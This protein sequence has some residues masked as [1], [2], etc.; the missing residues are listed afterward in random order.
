[1]P[2][3]PDGTFSTTLGTSTVSVAPAE[4]VAAIVNPTYRG[5]EY[6]IVAGLD[7]NEDGQLSPQEIGTVYGKDPD[8]PYVAG[9]KLIFSRTSSDPSLTDARLKAEEFHIKVINQDGYDRQ[10]FKYAAL[11]EL[12]S[13]A[14]NAFAPGVLLAFAT[15]GPLMVPAPPFQPGTV[16]ARLGPPEVIEPNRISYSHNVGVTWDADGKA[17]IPHYIMDS[18]T[19]MPSKILN[20]TIFKKKIEELI[21][22]QQAQITGSFG[23]GGSDTKTFNFHFVDSVAFGS[24]DDDP[25]VKQG[26]EEIFSID[27]FVT[28]FAFTFGLCP[29]FDLFVGIGG[30]TIDVTVTV[31]F[32]AT[33]F[34]VDSSTHFVQ[35][36]DVGVQGHLYDLYDWDFAQFWP[37]D[38]LATIEAGFG[39]LGQGG[40]VFSYEIL[41]DDDIGNLGIVLPP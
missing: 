21:A 4:S 9:K 30:A 13:V 32:Q 37:D 31:T 23:S 17:R 19:G 2:A 7:Y 40:K 33:P 15:G 18:T 38:D 41:L 5:V 11:G 6:F 3:D 22:R 1:L 8:M 35:V 24:A 27:S 10:Q 12:A 29:A 20:S 26:F 28:K 34:P 39:T 14:R 16:P 25:C 36:G